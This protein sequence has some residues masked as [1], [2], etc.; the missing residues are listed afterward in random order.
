M[1][2]KDLFVLCRRRGAFAGDG[3]RFPGVLGIA[4]KLGELRL[5]RRKLGQLRRKLWRRHGAVL[6]KLW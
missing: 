2:T 5:F 3:D 6:G 4:R 1:T